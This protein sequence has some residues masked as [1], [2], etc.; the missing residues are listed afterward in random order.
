MTT[1]QE[2]IEWIDGFESHCG[3]SDLVAHAPYTQAIRTRL[4]VA[5]GMAEALKEALKLSSDENNEAF[6]GNLIAREQALFLWKHNTKQ[7]LSK[8]EALK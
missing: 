8:W 1:T 7:T 3:K 4:L 6:H 5:Q 2:L